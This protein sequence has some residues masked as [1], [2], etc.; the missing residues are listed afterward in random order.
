MLRL[1][2]TAGRAETGAIRT[3]GVQ[4]TKKTPRFEPED[5]A[6]IELSGNPEGLP[7]RNNYELA[8]A[9]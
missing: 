5:V 7:P 8:T 3:E 4:S 2:Q 1:K 6:F 9:A